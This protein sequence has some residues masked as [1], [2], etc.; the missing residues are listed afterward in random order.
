MH[1]EVEERT[2]STERAG[3]RDRILQVARAAFVGRGYADVSMQ[4]I[5]AAAGL[6]KP[7]IYY[8]FTDKQDLFEAVVIA[9]MVRL[10]HGVAEQLAPG[11]PLRAQLERV[12]A[13]ALG[14]ERGDLSRLIADAQRYCGR[15]RLRV[16]KAQIET[17]FGLLRAAFVAAQER[18][19]IG[20][21]DID[22]VLTLFLNMIE[23]QLKGSGFGV[24][25]DAS[26]ED[27][28]RSIT[29]LLMDGIA[30]SRWTPLHSGAPGKPNH[31]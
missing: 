25:I 4:E 21:S 19:E 12:A 13:F 29:N 3:G 20:D 26:P 9:E 15:D 30:T 18:G 10:H 28:A 6:T 23:G 7:A 24:V 11:P 16:L 17:P 22:R 2:V 1:V 14:A 5:A 27:L 31:S 8:H